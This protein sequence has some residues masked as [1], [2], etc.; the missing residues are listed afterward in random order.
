MDKVIQG[1]IGVIDVYRNVFECCFNGKNCFIVD[2]S[3][4]I[5]VVLL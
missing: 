5:R 1:E 3:T 2:C 4:E